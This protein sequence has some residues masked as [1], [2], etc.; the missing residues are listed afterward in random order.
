MSVVCLQSEDGT[1][2][3]TSEVLHE[4]GSVTLDLALPLVHMDRRTLGYTH[5]T[6]TFDIEICSGLP[7]ASPQRQREFSVMPRVR[8]LFLPPRRSLG[9]YTRTDPSA[10]TC[11]DRTT[12]S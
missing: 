11:S 8:K 4:G 2:Y 10:T 5:V 1:P 9:R 3:S 12:T 6:F 7:L